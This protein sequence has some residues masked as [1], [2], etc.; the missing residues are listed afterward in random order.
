MATPEGRIQAAILTKLKKAGVF[1]WRNNNTATYDAKLGIYRAFN[2]TKGVSD[3]IA[4][5]P[6]GQAC[7]IEV[8]T[9]KG[10]QSPDQILFQKRVEC[11][12][13]RYVLARSVSDV[14]KVIPT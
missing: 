10:R 9:P 6:G 12:G 1:C 7:F 8:K 3:I 5:L 2:G 13:A 4:V 14:E 11:L